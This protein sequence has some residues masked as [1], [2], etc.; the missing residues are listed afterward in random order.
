MRILLILSLCLSNIVAYSQISADNVR[1]TLSILENS[2]KN[3]DISLSKSI[4][5][6]N[7]SISTGSWE[8]MLPQILGN[9]EFGSLELVDE[10]F[11]TQDGA[12]I[13]KTKISF[14]DGKTADSRI[15]LDSD[16]KILYVEYFDRLYG[17]SRFHESRLV[18]SFPFEVRDGSIIVKVR[19][20][21]NAHP[22]SL[23]FDTG[24]DGMALRKTLA[25][26]LNLKISHSQQT[27]VV[28]GQMQV[29]IS[30][31][32]KVHLNDSI[33]LM[34]SSIAIFEQM[35]SADGILGIG[36]AKTYITEVNFDKQVI[37][38]YTLGIHEYKDKG[39]TL[40]LNFLKGLVLVPSSVNLTGK[41][42]ITGNFIMDTGAHY[43]LILFSR[44]VRK[45][46]LLLS[47]FKPEGQASTVSMGHTTPVFYGKAHE[48]KVG[49]DIVLND[50]P[51][52]L[53]SSTGGDT[54]PEG[55]PDGSI[56]VQVFNQFNF[57]ID[58][59][60]KKLHLTPRD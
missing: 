19:I 59:L 31:P 45:N 49:E 18:G 12:T 7:T 32:N 26:S 4:T 30:S 5:T 14:K 28:G 47:G 42:T 46:R 9:I 33:S 39:T 8:S 17:S 1:S 58:L 35:R 52:T 37:S 54:T 20:N 36:L 11:G 24:A 6:E 27:N 2:L 10:D 3:K 38:L 44:Y 34:N 50:M 41:K 53:Q 23:L 13:I 57:T 21:D 15:A 43:H 29:N 60:S 48:F 16:N 40:P 56:G 55:W 51:I 25:D 22:V